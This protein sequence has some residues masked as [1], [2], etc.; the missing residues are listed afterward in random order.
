VTDLPVGNYLDEISVDF[1]VSLPPTQLEEL[2]KTVEALVARRGW[3]IC[4]PPGD[5]LPYEHTFPLFDG[6]DDA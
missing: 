4:Y 3:E 2:V 1:R 5:G 6:V